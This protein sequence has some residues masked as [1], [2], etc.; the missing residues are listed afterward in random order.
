MPSSR[1][2]A[3]I[4]TA[5][6]TAAVMLA[7]P[8]ATA[9]L[10]ATDSAA[11][12]CQHITQPPQEGSNARLNGVGVVS[13]CNAW[14]VGFDSAGA[15]GSTLV[16]HWNGATWTQVA[17]PN[18]GKAPVSDALNAIS[19]VSA[20]D[21][22]AVGSA[23]SGGVTSAL[24]EHW[25][26][27]KWVPVA[28]PKPGGDT[29]QSLL[30]GIWA[31]SA[32]SIWAVG[33]S[34][35]GPH[36]A[37]NALIEHWNGA[38]WK[39]VSLKLA[40]PAKGTFLSAVTGTSAKQ[41]WATGFYC[42]TETKCVPSILAWNGSRWRRSSIP[43]LPAADSGFLYG[44]SALSKT[45]AWAVGSAQ[46]TNAG[47]PLI[48]HWNGRTWR[49]MKV[50]YPASS[51]STL[52]AVQA[53]SGHDVVAVGS[54]EPKPTGLQTSLTITWNGTK[55]VTGPIRDPLG[56]GLNYSLNAIAGH[57]CSTAWLVGDGYQASNAERPVA[58]RC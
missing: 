12:P 51:F 34:A 40:G 28:S 1:W 57:S 23:M 32:T 11:T 52:E 15:G 5:A 6:T 37:I 19:V 25:T 44:I 41:V 26:G 38:K 20:S 4:V 46:T 55:W 49:R 7:A 53:F 48:E 2:T 58:V 31:S 29:S 17:S 3:R 39:A 22:W 30:Q 9:A 16:D 18:P 42:P 43:S 21:A 35:S 8:A 24:I 54:Y 13:A 56:A 10:A 47:G 33:Y 45:S 50:A 36:D 14:A 27:G